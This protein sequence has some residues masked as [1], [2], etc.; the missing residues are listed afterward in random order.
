MPYYTKTQSF[1]LRTISLLDE[2]I[3]I[4]KALSK[5]DK[6]AKYVPSQEKAVDHTIALFG[7]NH[8]HKKMYSLHDRSGLIEAVYRRH[9]NE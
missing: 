3:L 2:E 4:L 6:N 7:L 9:Y 5:S 1:G 8:S